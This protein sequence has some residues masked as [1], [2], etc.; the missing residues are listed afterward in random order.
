M[1]VLA[2]TTTPHSLELELE[3]DAASVVTLKLRRNGPNLNVHAEGAELAPAEHGSDTSN[4]DSLTVKFPA[5][6]GYQQ[7]KVT[8]HW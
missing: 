2:E 3:A 5:G 1:K 6:I 4:V 7:Q 8:L